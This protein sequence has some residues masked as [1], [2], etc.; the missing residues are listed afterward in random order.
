VRGTRSSVIAA[1]DTDDP[2]P[3][4]PAKSDRV[5]TR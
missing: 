4:N 3:G 1:G 5:R 2:V